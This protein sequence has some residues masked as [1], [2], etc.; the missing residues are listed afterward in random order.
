MPTHLSSF[1]RYKASGGR[2]VSTK[3]MAAKDVRNNAAVRGGLEQGGNGG[4]GV[5]QDCGG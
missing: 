4:R 2:E 3:A 5:E 1:A